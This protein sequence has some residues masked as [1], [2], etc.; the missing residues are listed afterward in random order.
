MTQFEKDFI[1][2]CLFFLKAVLSSEDEL[3]TAISS[4]SETKS[5]DPRYHSNSIIPAHEYWAETDKLKFSAAI[6][7]STARATESLLIHPEL[8]I[9][10]SLATAYWQSNTIPLLSINT[11]PNYRINSIINNCSCLE[12]QVSNV[13]PSDNPSSVI[14]NNFYGFF[15]TAAVGLTIAAIGVTLALTK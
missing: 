9:S 15:T 6:F 11:D 13:V 4:Y 12:L 1:L 14:N 5:S 7:E 3:N 8:S 10:V 2:K